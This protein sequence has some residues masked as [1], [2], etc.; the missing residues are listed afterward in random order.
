M[1][2]EKLYSVADLEGWPDEDVELINGAIVR[3]P[4]ARV[5]HGL[6]QA[7]LSDEV[8]PLRRRAGPTGWWIVTEVS[9]RYGEHQCP[10]HDLAGW[11]KER[12]PERPSGVMTLPPDWV[13]EILSPGHEKKDLLYQLMLLQSEGVPYYWVVSPEDATL[14]V[15]ALESGHYRVLE[16]ME[17][18]AA[19]P[20][21]TARLPPFEMLEIDLR[22]VLGQE[23][24]E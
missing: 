18:T 4:M 7:A 9:V 19:S 20:C 2:A 16:S 13:C 17:C 5:E 24:P 21:G 11:R 15:Y 10:T 22:Y 12:V 1:E 6:V 3:R 23:P 14:I 8:R